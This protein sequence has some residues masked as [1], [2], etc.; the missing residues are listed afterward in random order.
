MSLKEINEMFRTEFRM[1]DE[2]IVDRQGHKSPHIGMIADTDD[3]WLKLVRNGERVI[4]PALY[5]PPH[6]TVISG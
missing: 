2:V 1:G 4:Y 3:C 5:Y 6:C